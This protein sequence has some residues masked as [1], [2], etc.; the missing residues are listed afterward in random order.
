MKLCD[1]SG[2]EELEEACQIFESS[3]D[4]ED[5]KQFQKIKFWAYER[6]LGGELKVGHLIKLKGGDDSSFKEGLYRLV[7]TSVSL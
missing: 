6:Q 1:Q 2:K 4:E 5:K 3:N 7:I